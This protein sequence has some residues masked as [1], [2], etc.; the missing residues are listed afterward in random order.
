[1]F[2]GMECIDGVGDMKCIIQKYPAWTCPVLVQ[3][4]RVLGMKPT[5]TWFEI[6]MYQDIN[7]QFIL[8]MVERVKIWS[9]RKICSQH[10]ICSTTY[11]IC[12]IVWYS[13]IQLPTKNFNSLPASSE[14]LD[15]VKVLNKIFK[16]FWIGKVDRKHTLRW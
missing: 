15:T 5:Y 16:T 11:E 14:Q 6:C 13:W 3:V 1:M 9:C 12:M 2:Y 8:L 7:F 10:L 4:L